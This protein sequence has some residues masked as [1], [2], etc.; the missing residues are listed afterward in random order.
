MKLQ[1]GPPVRSRNSVS[2]PVSPD[3]IG[4]RDESAFGLEVRDKRRRG[5]K[6][7]RLESRGGADR[8]RAAGDKIDLTADRL[9]SRV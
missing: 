5:E 1:G 4:H 9:Q 6:Q 8:E 7:T 2:R 3:V